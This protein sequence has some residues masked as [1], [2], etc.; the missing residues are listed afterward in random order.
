VHSIDASSAIRVCVLGEWI[1]AQLAEVLA[2]QRAEEPETAIVLAGETVADPSQHPPSEH[3]DFVISTAISQ[4]SGWESE[5][6]W[7]D[8]LAIAVPKRSHLLAFREI[9]WQ[10]ALKQ[11]FVGA[12]SATHEGWWPA[13]EHVLTNARHE[14]TH[15]VASMDLAMTLVAAGYGIT[16]APVARLSS[17]LHRGV[18]LR[19][20]SGA[21]AITTAYL[22]RPDEPLTEP[23]AR[24]A[25]RLRSVA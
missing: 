8:A 9:P 25:Q 16:I 22:L 12:L 18:A 7:H 3:C 15:S 10:E 1:P 11:P 21:S 5:P 24:F 17:Y 23:H 4:W 20:L 2:L 6:L 19:R 13:V 14:H